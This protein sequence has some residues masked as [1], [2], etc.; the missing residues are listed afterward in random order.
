MPKPEWQGDPVVFSAVANRR[1]FADVS[2]S[3]IPSLPLIYSTLSLEL[4]EFS[5]FWTMPVKGIFS[6]ARTFDPLPTG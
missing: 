3:K 6:I 1:A 2:A 4:Y 5:H